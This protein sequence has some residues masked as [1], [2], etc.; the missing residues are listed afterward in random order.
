MDR[1]KEDKEKKGEPVFLFNAGDFL[2]GSPFGW[3]AL[4]DHA[5]ELKIMQKIGYD[6][7]ILGNHEFDCGPDVLASYLQE[8]DYPK[9]HEDTTLLATNMNASSGHP[10]FKEELYRN[11]HVKKIEEDVKLGLFG[12]MGNDAIQTIKDTEGIEFFEPEK[13]ARKAVSELEKKGADIIVALTHSGFKEDKTLAEEVDGIDLI[14]GGHEHIA[15]YEPLYKGDTIIVQAGSELEYLGQLELSYNKKTGNVKVRNIEN[16]NPFLNPINSTIT[17]QKKILSLVDEYK[18]T[19][20]K[21]V[22]NLTR[23]EYNS[24]LETVAISDFKISG[25]PSDREN[26][27]GNFVT[28]AMRFVTENITGERVDV[29]LQSSGMIRKGIQ[30]SQTNKTK[31]KISFYDLTEVTA[32][33]KG[34][35]NNPGYPIVSF[36]LTGEE[37]RRGL[38][39][40]V[41]M[42]ILMDEYYFLQ[43]SGISY[44]Y[45]PS[46]AILFTVPGINLPIPTKRAVK[47]VEVYTGEGFQTPPENSSEY[48]SIR[49]GDEKLYHIV[50]DS[51]LLSF[52]PL[53]GEFFPYLEIVPKDSSGEPVSPDNMDELKVYHNGRELKTW[54]SVLI[55]A[56]SKSK[57]DKILPVIP[58]YYNETSDRINHME[59]FPYFKW[60]ILSIIIF[61]II[62]I[63]ALVILIKKN[64]ILKKD[65]KIKKKQ[66]R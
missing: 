34:D 25:Q 13:S 48:K 5:P 14:V 66:K 21:L 42:E 12:I 51:Y 10:L 44:S 19:L 60:S 63:P 37:L 3:L 15:L 47:N 55:Y 64:K 23:K 49:R 7:V 61:T 40:G 43:L 41:L 57:G 54:E 6:A 36:Y 18:Q 50:A 45:N 30:P 31:G 59:A 11:L 8:A 33:G 2:G 56:D 65:R 27:A 32:M 17:S 62:L 28:D 1:I 20:N 16:E 52:L 9:A 22:Y 46:D 4:R 35:D 53:A 39:G 29:A 24:V 58:E 38:E 26:P